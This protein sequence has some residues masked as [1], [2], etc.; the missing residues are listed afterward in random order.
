MTLGELLKSYLNGERTAINTI[1]TLSGMFDPASAV[2]ILA[3]ICA[4]TRIE[5]GD[6]DKDTFK[7]MFGLGE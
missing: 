5:E 7:S 3:L 6:L 2:N 1:R 4:I